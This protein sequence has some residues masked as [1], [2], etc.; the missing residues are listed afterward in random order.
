M[1][2]TLSIM[3]VLYGVH[4]VEEALRAGKRQFEGEVLKS[5]SPAQQA[6]MILLVED[7]QARIRETL[8]DAR[9]SG[10]RL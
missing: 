1:A 5:L 10:G 6:R 2:T 7:I 8:R 9:R 4:P 3:E